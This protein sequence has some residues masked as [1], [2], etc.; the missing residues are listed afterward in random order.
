MEFF[1]NF[2]KNHTMMKKIAIIGIFFLI[3]NSV[4]AQ[5]LLLTGSTSI[6]T[7]D[8]CNTTHANILVKNI[9]NKDLNVVCQKYNIDTTDGTSNYFCWGGSCY[10]ENTF[11]SPNTQYIPAGTSTDSSDFGGYY[12]A[13]CTAA[14]AKIK[15]CFYPDTDPTNVSC[16]TVL[17]NGMAS[18]V[19]D[20]IKDGNVG[21][22]FPN[23]ADNFVHIEHKLGSNSRLSVVDVLGNS[24]KTVELKDSGIQKIYVGDLQK[25]MYFGRFTVKGKLVAMKRIVIKR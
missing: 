8:P 18:K 16:L 2:A 6:P 25:G 23:P 15:Y 9:T 22:F 5:S 20:N 3:T 24:V 12:D 7:A 21:S 13:Y 11:I 17:Y 4:F 10:G 1:S 19:V 14:T